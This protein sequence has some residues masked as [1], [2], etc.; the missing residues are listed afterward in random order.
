MDLRPL[1]HSQNPYFYPTVIFL[2][3]VCLCQDLHKCK[4]INEVGLFAYIISQ[5]YSSYLLNLFWAF[6]RRCMHTCVC[7]TSHNNEFSHWIRTTKWN[8]KLYRH[9]TSKVAHCF[10][11]PMCP[12]RLLAVLCNHHCIFLTFTFYSDLKCHDVAGCFEL[13]L[14]RIGKAIC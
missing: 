5:A 1:L 12:L 13:P 4:C 9:C 7:E 14:M 10:G 8:C 3:N 2:D 6:D 11:T